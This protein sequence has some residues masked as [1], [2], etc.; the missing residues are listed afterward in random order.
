MGRPK[1]DAVDVLEVVEQ[2]K[3]R[4]VLKKNFGLTHSARSSNFYP[5]GTEFDAE[6]DSALVT[7]LVRNGA[8]FE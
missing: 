4:F 2:A 5:A 6:K 1:Q 7:E 8:I 3:P